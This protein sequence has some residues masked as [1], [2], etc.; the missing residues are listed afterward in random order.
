MCLLKIEKEKVELLNSDT[1]ILDMLEDAGIHLI[2]SSTSRPT[3]V[4]ALVAHYSKFNSKKLVLDAYWEGAEQLGLQ[5]L[6]KE[7]T[8]N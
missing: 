1:T 2:V 3:I 6:L 4:K 7:H 5:T 8:S